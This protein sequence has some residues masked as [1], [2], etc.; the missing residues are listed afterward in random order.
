MK[1]V[2]LIF[3]LFCF[4]LSIKARNDSI[5][6]ELK[7]LTNNTTARS[8]EYRKL[9]LNPDKQNDTIIAALV[10]VNIL[11]NNKPVKGAVF[12]GSAILDSDNIKYEDG[13][14]WVYLY[15][16][17]YRFDIA[18]DVPSQNINMRELMPLDPDSYNKWRGV[19]SGMTY[20]LKITLPD[21]GPEIPKSN[22]TLSA[23]FNVLPLIGPQISAGFMTHNFC[24]EVGLVYGLGKSKDT[25]IY[26]SGGDLQD[27]YRYA[28]M[29]A[30][31]RA[32]YE[33]WAADVFSITPQVGV[34][35]NN[36]HGSRLSVASGS[37]K[38]L[39]GATAI[40]AT[41]G[42]RFMYAPSGRTKP[43]RLFLTPEFDVAVSKDKNFKALADYDSKIKSWAEGLGL[44]FGLM[45]YF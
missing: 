33:I 28:P 38:V 23:G 11:Q 27:A 43:I 34:A 5:K 42:A 26:N 35:I 7:E 4:A 10:F 9:Y 24:A 15:K 40:S 29:R 13:K 21:T 44:S 36:I 25:Y 12:N 8:Y 30:F 3:A 14:Y 32:G 16:G 19:E 41:V 18:G 37:E 22:F 45:Y 39:S 17:Y 1:K 20:E 31:L 6:Y 2:L